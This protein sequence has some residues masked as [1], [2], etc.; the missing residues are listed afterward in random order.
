MQLVEQHCISKSDPRYSVIDEAAFKLKN[1]YNAALYEMRQAFIQQGIYLSYEE[2]DK[3]MQLHEAYRALPAKV[4]QQVLRQLSDAW[5][6]FR[7]A[8]VAYEENPSK[9]TGRPKLPKYKHKTEGRNILIYNIQAISRGKHG[10]K[11]G[12]IKP[13]MLP[14][15]VKTEKDPKKIDQVRIVPRNGHYVVEVI[16]SKEPVQA[17]VDPSFCVAIDLGVT[18]V[19]A[20]TANRE[21][22]IPRLVNGRTLKAMNQ[23]YNKRMK[24][25]KLCLPKEDR[26][27]V[28]KQM[29]QITNKGNRQVNHYLHAASK[30]IIDFLVQEGVGTIIVGKNPLWKQEAGMGRRNNQNFVQIPHARFI[31]MLTYKAELV[32]I[33]VEVQEESYTSKASFL[34]LDPIPTYKPNND[35]QYTFSGKRIGRRNRLYR[36]K[37]GKIIC[38]DV[39]GSYNILRK[40]KPD[41]FAQAGAKGL[42]AY[43]VQPLRLAI[44]V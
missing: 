22:F 23:W 40:R 6:A 37:S 27:R 26:E 10:L 17:H 3:R 12:I 2:M 4:S 19:A 24:E 31:K 34:D 29:E 33:R 1:L 30:A 18:N 44:T 9:F 36:T 38:A 25:L 35:T 21:G 7:E 20:I 8:K 16:Y 28:T 32:G 14:I 5:K 11:R 15:E 39:N 41:A 13:S 42:A 43:V